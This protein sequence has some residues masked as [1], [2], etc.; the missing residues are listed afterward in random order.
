MSQWPSAKA[1]LVKRALL[2]IGWV[3]I[4]QKGSHVKL[5]HPTRGNYMFGFHD[6]EEIGHK[7][8]GQDRKTYRTY[9]KRSIKTVANP[10]L[11][12]HRRKTKVEVVAV[13]AQCS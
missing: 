12:Q 2:R 1:K 11:G 6:D 10:D 7:N 3:V 9:S 8:V 5:S 4:S 13:S